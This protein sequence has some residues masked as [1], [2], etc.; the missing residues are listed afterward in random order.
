[1]R[2]HRNEQ[3]E[4]LHGDGGGELVQREKPTRVREEQRASLERGLVRSLVGPP[5]ELVRHEVSALRWTARHEREFDL[6]AK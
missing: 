4:A 1:M 5:R 6:L 2:K 3:R